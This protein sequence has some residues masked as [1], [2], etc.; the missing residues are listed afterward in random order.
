MMST[1]KVCK[2]HCVLIQFL[3]SV[4]YRSFLSMFL[5][6]SSTYK[7]R[8]VLPI[9]KPWTSGYSWSGSAIHT[10]FTEEGSGVFSHYPSWFHSSNNYPV[11]VGL[12]RVSKF[13]PMLINPVQIFIWNYNMEELYGKL[14]Q[15]WTGEKPDLPITRGNRAAPAG[16]QLSEL[17]EQLKPTTKPEDKRTA[18]LHA[19][20]MG[21][22]HKMVDIEELIEMA[23]QYLDELMTGAD[24]PVSWLKFGNLVN[25][26]LEFPN[27][28]GL[29]THFVVHVPVLASVQG[30]FK[31]DKSTRSVETN[32]VARFNMKLTSKVRTA[33]PW[34]TKYIGSGVDVRLDLHAPRRINVKLSK[35]G[36]FEVK[37]SLSE[38]VNDI[39]HFHV[40]PYTI[41]REWSTIPTLEDQANVRLVRTT[42]SPFKN[43]VALPPFLDNFKISMETDYPFN[44]LNSWASHMSKFDLI[45]WMYQFM[46]PLRLH[47]REY[48]IKYLPEA[49]KMS[50]I[51]TMLHYFSFW[52][53]GSKSITYTSGTANGDNKPIES[54]QDIPENA[55]EIVERLFKSIDNGVANIIHSAVK[56]DQKDG[57]TVQIESSYGYAQDHMTSKSYRDLR[58]VHSNS[59]TGVNYSVCGSSSIAQSQP[60][61]FG[62]SSE[63]LYQTEDGII[64]MGNKCESGDKLSYKVKLIRDEM[65]AKVARETD[66]AQKCRL[67]M[68]SGLIDSPSCQEARQLD[69]TFNIYQLDVDVPKLPEKFT[70]YTTPVIS[71]LA[72]YMAPFIV[73]HA[74]KTAENNKWT[75]KASRQPISGHV[76]VILRSP[77]SVTYARNVH[78][79]NATWSPAVA[80]VAPAFFPIQVDTSYVDRVKSSATGGVSE[81][82]C[83]VGEKRVI[84]YDS[85]AYNYTL[86]ECDHVLV[87]DCSQKS[88]FAVLARDSN[89]RKIVTVVLHKD[90][91]EVDPSGSVTING[92]S[93]SLDKDT[94][95]EIFDGKDIIVSVFRIGNV[96]NM[97]LSR[98]GL[99]LAV[100]NAQVTI[101]GP[102]MLRGRTC[103]ICG[104]FDQEK[105]HE[106]KTPQRCS[107][108]SGSIMA[109]SY[110]V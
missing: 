75:L 19:N 17:F 5:E 61:S 110:Q 28:L 6:K 25:F 16:P 48:R 21:S 51:S 74:S 43:D 59:G 105:F 101:T 92:E 15:Q 7:A 27:E 12:R 14:Y 86:G 42:E 33:F 79:S 36:E 93:K 99:E 89:G 62:F 35:N 98:I 20:L 24:T 76:D 84:T 109:T 70:M 77:T 91:V 32:A 8:G 39:M 58:W 23:P 66:A 82:R 81:S 96:M 87:T 4:N 69:Q 11:A 56:F 106:H 54:S 3:M 57:T 63:P 78:F 97:E 95:F 45:S 18:I 73:S 13:G 94:R 47:Q 9:V 107:V 65:A 68:K 44:D 10:K 67:Q 22:M 26:D 104:D 29:T 102:W 88:N 38:K 37:L 103:G 55:K 49:G 2:L 53:S 40:M 72:K 41:S 71:M 1:M 52:R 31:L 30:S 64:Q 108:S 90:V 83:F 100:N 50:S 34:N 85:V 46:V 80:T 60:P